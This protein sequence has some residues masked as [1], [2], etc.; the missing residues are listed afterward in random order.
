LNRLACGQPVAFV[1]SLFGPAPLRRRHREGVTEHVFYT[2]HA[3]VQILADDTA[4]TLRFSMTV[5][6]E[7]F[8]F[9]VA[10]L[11][12]GQ[13]DIRLGRSRFWNLTEEEGGRLLGIG[14]RGSA[15]LEAYGFGDDAASQRYL[16]AFNDAG[17]GDFDRV[18]LEE[19]GMSCLREG[20]FADG[21][22]EAHPNAIVRLSTF[23][24]STS[25]NTLTVVAAAA[26]PA[27]TTLLPYGVDL[28][29]IR[30]FRPIATSRKRAA[31][32]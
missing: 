26:D 8:S 31:R 3:L 6:D 4:V 20:V 11:T 7:R 5:T 12:F 24:S 25:V 27:L 32:R 18:A 28:E 17:V 13:T 19:S 1:A 15:Y 10:D 9:R 23:R 30:V 22:T 21:Q 29:H 14:A 2:P 16:F